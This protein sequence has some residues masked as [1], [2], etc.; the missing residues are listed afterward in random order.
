MDRT[1][2]ADPA[3][4]TLI[5]R[6]FVPVRVDADRRPDIG[7]RY[8]LG[9]WPT[10]A[11]LDADGQVV[12]GGTFIAH[13]RMPAV[14][15]RVAEAFATRAD[16]MTAV[17]APAVTS[18]SDVQSESGG[19]DGLL[20]RV[21]ASFDAEHGGFG[22]S[23]KFP[24]TSPVHLALDVYRENHD[25]RMAEVAVATLDA[26]GWGPLY[27]EVDGGFFRYAKRADW[28]A[29]QYEKLLDV[30]AALLRAYVD[31]WET[32]GT[33]RYR[34]RA[35][36][37]LRYL[38][39]WLADQANGGWAGSQEAAPEYYSRE[40]PEE[41][42]AVGPPGTDPIVYAG[43]NGAA[44]SAA[45]RAAGALAD[46]GLAAFALRSLERVL[47][48]CYRPGAG[49][50]HYFD[51]EA[52]VRGLLDDQ[53]ATATACLD[54][55][56]ASGDITYEMMAEELARYA[57]RT[58]WDDERGGFFDR[59]VGDEDGGIGLMGRRL[60]PFDVNCQ[61][62]VALG[63]LAA[64]SGEH[65]FMTMAQSTLAAMAADAPRHGPQAAHYLLA[66]RAL[67]VR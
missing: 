62:A 7:E 28:Q 33:A 6:G 23:P 34:A 52:R 3:I 35:E 59:T 51:G 9:G 47:L 56:D 22:G 17:S 63:R 14:L 36:D 29:P 24:L 8:S 58:M 13:D 67:R 64:T 4:V 32:F 16:E 25:T 20:T 38:Q 66:V 44:V 37:V 30:N 27:D 50:A 57:V 54:A 48:E 39:T 65:D 10:T 18:P 21:F 61:A 53:I 26:I 40:T 12:G 46:Q 1:S 31:A 11:F 45:F 5:D 42:R 41:R 43:W 15:A 2:Y 55:Y 49:V 60:K 19:E